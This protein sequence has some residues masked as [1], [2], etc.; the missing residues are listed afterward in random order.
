M[1]RPSLTALTM[2]AKLSSV[3]IISAAPLATSVPV[4]PIAQPMSA[5]LR[6]GASFTP[7]PVI[8][9]TAPL[10]CHALTMRILSSGETRA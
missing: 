7:S 6:A 9:T 4:T 5:A 2:V 10:F 3:R 8:D 1:P